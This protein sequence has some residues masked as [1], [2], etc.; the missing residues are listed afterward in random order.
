[1]VTKLKNSNGDIS[2]NQNV[3]KLNFRQNSKKSLVRNNLTP[4]QPMRCTQGSLLRSC[5]VSWLNDDCAG[6][7]KF[8]VS[9]TSGNFFISLF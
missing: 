4:G 6:V 3:T 8:D 2:K 5:D 9:K 7:M 1:M